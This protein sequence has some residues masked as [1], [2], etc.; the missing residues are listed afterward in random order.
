MNTR[1][2]LMIVSII[3]MLTSCYMPPPRQP[4]SRTGVNLDR[5]ASG[6][7]SARESRYLQEE[8]TRTQPDPMIPPTGPNAPAT[9]DPAAVQPPAGTPLPP[10]TTEQPTTPPPPSNAGAATPP[11]VPPAP[12]AAELPYGVPVPGKKGFVYSPYDKSAG[13]VDVRDI[14]PGT[15]VRCPYTGK[16]FR[17]P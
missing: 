4:G 11:L 6:D 3:T 2:L 16:I 9:T 8:V 12:A 15:K 5:P 17:V 14:G 1:T 10:V 7:R 13:F